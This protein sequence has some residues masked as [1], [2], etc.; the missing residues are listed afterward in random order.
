MVSGT[1]AVNQPWRDAVVRRTLDCVHG[2]LG[3]AN[4]MEKEVTNGNLLS[5]FAFSDLRLGFL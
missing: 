2:S 5:S 3:A 4:Q 1:G